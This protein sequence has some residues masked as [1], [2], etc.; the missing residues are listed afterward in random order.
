M[1]TFGADDNVKGRDLKPRH[2]AD[3]L[4]YY[5]NGIHPHERISIYSNDYIWPGAAALRLPVPEEVTRNKADWHANG[6]VNISR[7]SLQWQLVDICSRF[8]ELTAEEPV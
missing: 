7:E 4:M 5:F 6:L 8:T 3:L 2:N 1:N